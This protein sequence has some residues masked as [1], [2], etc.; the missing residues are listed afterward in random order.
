MIWELEELA[1]ERLEAANLGA[2]VHPDTLARELGFEVRH[3]DCR[4]KL[5]GDTVYVSD[6]LRAEM[7]AFDIC[8][9][10]GH[11]ICDEAGIPSTEWRANYLASALLLPRFE[12]EVDLRRVGWDLLALK[13]R[14]RHASFE[15][16]GRRIVALR[17]A[18]AVIFDRPLP[19]HTIRPPRPRTAPHGH[20]PTEEERVA[21]REAVLSG[22]PVELRAGLT[23]WPVLQ[24]DWHRAITVRAL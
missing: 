14:H 11:R 8:H 3:A 2:P 16:V 1:R 21:A 20:R 15:A 12:F 23:A 9:E 5:I 22:A 6:G 4:G 17:E 19:P 24:H 7:R 13:A 10:I 18:R